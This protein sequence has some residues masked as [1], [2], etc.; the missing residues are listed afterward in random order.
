MHAPP[1][2]PEPAAAH[3]AQ[4]MSDLIKSQLGLATP[5][6]SHPVFALA[7][8]PTPH[9]TP[10]P[11]EA[12]EHPTMS[13]VSSPMKTSLETSSK[14]RPEVEPGVALASADQARV[15]YVTGSAGRR[16]QLNV[17]PITIYK[18][19]EQ[20]SLGQL[21]A[22]NPSFICYSVKGEMVRILATTNSSLRSLL[23][24]HSKPVHDLAFAP[25]LEADGASL[26]A[27]TAKDGHCFV[28]R[29]AIKEKD[30]TTD[31]IAKLTLEEG[32]F[33]TRVVWNPLRPAQLVAIRADS[34]VHIWSV[35]AA[36]PGSA[37]LLR[38]LSPA[39]PVLAIAFS[40]ASIALG[41]R[42]GNVSLYSQDTGDLQQRWQPHGGK[43]VTFVSLRQGTIVTGTRKNREFRLWDLQTSL[44]AHEFALL[45]P[46]PKCVLTTCSHRIC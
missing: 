28:W 20:Y 4:A 9:Y 39:S 22:V 41:T 14:S 12:R 19:E 31:T 36:A 27:S 30:I 13:P 37:T 17:T 1:A 46:Q 42:D 35:S 29:I 32:L 6:P 16:V 23:R 5:Q 40:D 34:E 10:A 26:L 38:K 45:A 44:L 24:G 33:Y 8:H 18:T 25:A 11:V 7:S 43:A 15:E 21:I 2:T 3:S